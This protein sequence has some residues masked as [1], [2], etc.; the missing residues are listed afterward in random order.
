MVVAHEGII[1]ARDTM[2]LQIQEINGEFELP[3]KY[4]CRVRDQSKR[5]AEL[6]DRIRSAPISYRKGNIICVELS[7][8]PN[9]E[10]AN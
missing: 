7:P 2:E 8:A 5:W 10:A 1:K 6:R 3:E 4:R 9:P